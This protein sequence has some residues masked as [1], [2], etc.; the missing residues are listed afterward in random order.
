M[1]VSGLFLSVLLSCALHRCP[2]FWQLL[3]CCCTPWL[4]SSSCTVLLCAAF[5]DQLQL[6][7]LLLTLLHSPRPLLLLPD[8]VRHMRNRRGLMAYHIAVHK[9]FQHLTELLH[10]DIP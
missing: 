9:G 1:Q 2:A 4:F 6:H 7:V 5:A 8:D 10:P 3:A